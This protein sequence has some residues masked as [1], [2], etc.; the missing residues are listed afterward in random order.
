[1]N[2]IHNFS[3]GPAILPVP[4]VNASVKAI[5]EYN[6][7]GMSVME[8][9]HRSKPIVA[10]FEETN[11]NV[12]D[13]MKL[14][15]DNYA[16]LFLGGGAS[17]QFAMVAYN[18][19]K[20]TADYINTGTWASNAIKEAKKLGN[21]NVAA[22]SEDTNFNYIPK[23]YNLSPNADYLHYTSNNTIFGTEFKHIPQ[24]NAPLIC[25]MSSDLFAREMDF[26]K[27]DLIYA[28]AQ[29]NIGP[30]GATMVVIKKSFL[31][32]INSNLLTMLSY[33]THVDK[34]SMFNTPPV[35]P[36]FVVG[37]TLKWIKNEGGLK[38]IEQRNI[39]KAN[40][41][42]NVVD[43]NSSFYKGSVIHKEDRSLM[44]LTF[45][46]P[47]EELEEKFIKEAKAKNLDGLKGHRSVGGVRASTYN[48]CPVESC[49][50]LADFMKE[51]YVNNK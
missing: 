38:A 5:E 4:V 24:T 12:L 32:K 39:H 37:E 21:V 28:G 42:Y 48:A 33:K 14:S 16:V 50:A 2:R 49:Q 44:N 40:L 45:N 10:M 27:F 41:I 20:G 19:L 6:G 30:A 26:S 46:L 34:E 31:D 15:A 17:M 43:E 8:M 23:A 36:V 22:S 25:D 9:S 35:F 13:L 3:A 29:K 11:A 18:F 47:S 1:M 51:F 7:L